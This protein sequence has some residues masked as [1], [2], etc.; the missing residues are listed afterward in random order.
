MHAAEFHA[1]LGN[2]EAGHRAVNA[3]GKQQA[4]LAVRAHRHALHGG[5]AFHGEIRMIADLDHH[6]VIRMI[7]VHGQLRHVVED[8]AARLAHNRRRIQRIALIRAARQHLE[9]AGKRFH[10]LGRLLTDGLEIVFIHLDRRADGMHAEHARDAADALIHIREIG[11]I[12][13]SLAHPHAAV[14]RAHGLTDVIHQF[15]H[16]ERAVLPLQKDLA[17]TN[18]QNFS[19]R[20]ISF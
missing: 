3:A 10:H 2:H 5:N 14:H 8:I 18:Q 13:A 1:A 16:E 12:K 20:F 9:C 7:D 17:E 15:F 4:G 11:Y 19:H 6:R